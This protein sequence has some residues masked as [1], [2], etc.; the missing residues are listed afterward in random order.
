MP[1]IGTL[2]L[3]GASGQTYAFDVYAATV[4]WA[5]NI[6]CVYCISK[7]TS[8]PDGGGDHKVIYIGHCEDLKERH[9]NH[10]KQECFETHGY[11]CISIHHQGNE[12]RRLQIETDLGGRLV[13]PVMTNARERRTR[14]VPAF[15]G[16]W[17][18]NTWLTRQNPIQRNAAA[19]CRPVN[20]A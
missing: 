5:D 8:K 7:R 2:T 9:A 19:G 12:A 13:L 17:H 6:A 16:Y 11:N 10:H 1:K 18:T 15:A 20:R 3:Q 14:A 4:N